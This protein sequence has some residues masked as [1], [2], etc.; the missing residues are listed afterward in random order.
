MKIWP[1]LIRG[2]CPLNREFNVL[3]F[4]NWKDISSV[5]LNWTKFVKEVWL[6]QEKKSSTYMESGQWPFQLSDH[7]ST[8]EQRTPQLT[9]EKCSLF[10]VFFALG[11]LCANRYTKIFIITNVYDCKNG[12]RTVGTFDYK[13]KMERTP[14]KHVHYWKSALKSIIHKMNDHLQRII[15]LKLLFFNIKKP[16]CL[17][18]FTFFR[19]QRG[20]AE[21]TKT[22]RQQ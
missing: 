9:V 17:L 8:T 4:T 2:W 20:T 12:L 15:H 6:K 10:F 1:L 21:D 11:I 22:A 7:V 14:I 18:Y 13:Q 16:F 3:P 19:I 5:K